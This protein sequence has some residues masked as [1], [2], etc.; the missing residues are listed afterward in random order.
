MGKKVSDEWT[1][2]L[3]LLHHRALHDAGYEERWWQQH[4]LDPKGEAEKLWAQ[5]HPKLEP[6]LRANLKAGE[7]PGPVESGAD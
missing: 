1:V 7:Q 2:P 5:S 3:C 4:R 6:L